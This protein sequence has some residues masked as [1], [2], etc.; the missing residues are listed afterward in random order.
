[1]LVLKVQFLMSFN[2]IFR[3]GLEETDEYI[4][5][6]A[7]AYHIVSVTVISDDAVTVGDVDIETLVFHISSF[8]SLKLI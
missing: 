6:E 5:F 1:M 2:I 3:T 7:L 4:S 8:Q